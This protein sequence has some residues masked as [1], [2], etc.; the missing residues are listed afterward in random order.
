V[1]VL[2]D[3]HS[4]FTLEWRGPYDPLIADAIK[5]NYAAIL[6]YLIREAEGGA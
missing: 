5:D 4:L 6:A 2:A 3:D 1:F